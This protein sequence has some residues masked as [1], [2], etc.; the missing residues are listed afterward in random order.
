[1]KNSRITVF[2]I[3]LVMAIIGTG[4]AI[5][6]VNGKPRMTFSQKIYDFGTVKEK[7]GPV[8]CEFPFVNDG[9]GNLVILDAKADCGCTRPEFPKKPVGPGQSGVIKVVYNPLGAPGA[10]EK[11]ITIHTNGKPSKVRLKIRGTVLHQ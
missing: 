10:F 7:G 5:S 6:A 3:V 11:V 4:V 1:M 2:I 9:E 8:A